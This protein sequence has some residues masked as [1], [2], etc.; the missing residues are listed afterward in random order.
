L[1][2][3]GWMGSPCKPMA[4]IAASEIRWHGVKDGVQR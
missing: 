4:P 1:R 2:L 3:T